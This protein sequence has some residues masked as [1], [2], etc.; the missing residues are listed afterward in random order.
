MN[1]LNAVRLLGRSTAPDRDL[2]L[3]HV[4]RLSDWPAELAEPKSHFV[5]FLA[6]DAKGAGADEI[7]GLARKLVAQGMVYL[8]AWGPDCERVHDIFDEVRDEEE[9]GE[10]AIVMTTWHADDDL[11]D[12]LWDSLFNALPVDAFIDSCKAFV[13]VIVDHAEWADEVAAAL[14]DVDQFN[15]RVLAREGT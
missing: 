11:D 8:C 6:M 15:H 13:A 12:A 10:D 9:S 14:S 1:S 5:V 4:N 3:A 2:Y 7:A